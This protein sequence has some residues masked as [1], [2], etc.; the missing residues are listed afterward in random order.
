MRFANRVTLQG[1]LEIERMDQ[2]ALDAGSELFAPVI[3]GWLWTDT[4]GLERHRVILADKPALGLLEMLRR[5]NPTEGGSALLSLNGT[6]F[7][8]AHLNGRPFVAVEGRLVAGVVNVKHVTLLSTPEAGLLRLLTDHRLRE[9]VYG[10]GE[11]READRAHMYRIVQE[12]QEARESRPLGPTAL[13]REAPVGA[14]GGLPSTPP[15]AGRESAASLG[16]RDG[17]SATEGQGAGRDR[18]SN[19]IGRRK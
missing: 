19:R 2:V 1:Y 6:Q 16:G 18:V 17:E 5:F 13:G 11:I 10:W 12:V 14:E 15:A 4:V 7:E 3:H 9:I 8:V